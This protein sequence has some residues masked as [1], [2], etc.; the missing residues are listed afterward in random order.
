[1]QV[2]YIILNKN[3]NNNIKITFIKSKIGLISQQKKKIKN[4]SC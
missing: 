2:V 4:H 1:M 3:N